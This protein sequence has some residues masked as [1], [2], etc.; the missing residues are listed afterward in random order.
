MAVELDEPDHSTCELSA[1]PARFTHRST[2]HRCCTRFNAC[3]SWSS[4]RR[5][6]ASLLVGR[7][8]IT[9]RSAEF[10]SV[11]MVRATW[12][13]RRDTRWRCTA[14]PTDF[15]TTSPILGPSAVACVRN[16]CTIRSGCTTRTPSLIVTLNSDDRVIR[17][18][19][20]S[21]RWSSVTSRSER[22]TA[23]RAP[24]GH[25]RPS[26]PS[27]HPQPEPVHPR[28]TPVIG[29]EGPLALGHGSFSSFR[30]GSHFPTAVKPVRM[31]P[32]LVS[33]SVSL[34]NRRGPQGLGRS[35][36]ATFGRLFEG[37]D[38]NS[39]GQ[40]WYHC[41]AKLNFHHTRHGL[42]VAIDRRNPPSDTECGRTV[43]TRA[44]TC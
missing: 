10:S 26:G 4:S 14:P 21:T 30:C 41:V 36:I 38:E 17:F 20:G 40:T 13:S 22:A 27:P 28:P 15:A 32:P 19:A 16:A 6:T 24:V 9:T 5:D 43:G 37:T 3:R 8:R 35:R 29:L 12:R 42:A 2:P 11:R 23:L 18:R 33:S 44:E 31:R 25:D 34:A 7:A 39:P 1:Q